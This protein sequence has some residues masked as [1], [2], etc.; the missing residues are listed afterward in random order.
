MTP[1]EYLELL[2]EI[3]KNHTTDNIG[4]N[5]MRK[6][7]YVSSSYDTRDSKVYTV[8]FREWFKAFHKTFSN[9]TLK[10]VLSWLREENEEENKVL[11]DEKKDIAYYVDK[12]F[13]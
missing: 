7:K 1:V 12:E 3:N 9:P 8:S 5:S 2:K 10:E 13:N 11:K 4:Q 6:I